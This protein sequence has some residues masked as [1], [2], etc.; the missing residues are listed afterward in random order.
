MPIRTTSQFWRLAGGLLCA[1]S[2]MGCTQRGPEGPPTVAARGKIVFTKGGDVFKLYD[3]QGAVELESLEQPGVKAIGSIE[4]DGSFTL[5]TVFDGGAKP[6]AVAGK[7]RVRL[8]LDES[9]Q[10][11]VAPQFLNFERSQVTV[12]VPGDIVVQVWR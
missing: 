2:I 10:K 5:N 3:T 9:A 1:V 11:L 12:T 8:N 4:E 7:H 6:G